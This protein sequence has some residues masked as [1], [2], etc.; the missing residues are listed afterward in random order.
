MSTRLSD[1]RAAAPDSGPS[2]RPARG[3]AHAPAR[4]PQRLLAAARHAAPALIGYLLV[5]A[6][7]VGVLLHWHAQRLPHGQSNLHYLS[8]LW[9]AVWYQNIAVHGYAGTAP[10]AGPYGLY[11]PYAFFPVYSMLIRT[12][13]WVLPLSVNHAALLIAWGS[14]LL[15]AWGI[16]AVAAKLYGRRA[17]VI[18][19]VLW[20]V[21]PY[22]VVE[23]LAYSELPF[24]ALAAWAMYAAVTRRWVWAGV[25]STLAGLTRP[26]G[27][28]VAAAVGIGAVCALGLQWWKDRRGELA[29]EDRLA[30]WRPLLGAAVAPLGFVGFIVWVGSV[31]GRW[32]AYFRI[33][34]A[35]QSHFDFGRSTYHSIRTMLTVAGPVW[36]TDVVVTGVLAGSVLLFAVCLLQRQPPTLLV[37]SAMM[38]LLALGDAAYFNSRARFLVPAFALLFPLAAALARVRTKGVAAVVLGSAALCSAAYGGYVVFVYTNSP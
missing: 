12:V 5:R 4:I 13:C 8:T 9:D 19:A 29:E 33:Q 14:A 34:D 30:W 36:M 38:L 2:A 10:T 7:A 20:G 23:S 15:A 6:L 31:K 17:G 18:A 24:T 27:V 3:I 35:W 28:A 21:T 11:Q 1:P 32:D 37:Y 22:A 25:L 16:F 26:T